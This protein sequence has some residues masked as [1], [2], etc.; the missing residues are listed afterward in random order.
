MSQGFSI[1]NEADDTYY[2]NRLR[3]HA[4]GLEG[5]TAYAAA[6]CAKWDE[7]SR[8]AKAP[9]LQKGGADDERE[10]RQPLPFLFSCT[11]FFFDLLSFISG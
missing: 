2:S 9:P 5:G 11:R 7:G 10:T 6:R 3:Y 8:A 4:I 1:L